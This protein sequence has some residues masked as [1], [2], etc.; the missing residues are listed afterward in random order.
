MKPSR[1]HPLIV[2]ALVLGLVLGAG[3]LWR[4][5]ESISRDQLMAFL[6]VFKGMGPWVF[7]GMM[8]LLPLFWVPVSPFLLL[9]PAFGLQVAVVGSASALSVNLLLAWFVSGKWFRP[10]FVRLVSRFGYSV[11]ELSDR[12]MLGV[13]VLLRITP[14]VP[15]PLQ[16]YLLGLAR[17]PLLKYLAVSLPI[18][19][20]MSASI[21]VLG[22]SIMTG[23]AQL[24]LIAIVLAV[25]I[26]LILRLWRSKLQAKAIVEEGS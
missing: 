24:A 15:F 11:P 14:G 8:A 16:N 26:A 13:A 12:S 25:A 2:L 22:E 20:A 4:F 7:F 3:V 9:A 6:E 5:R 18:V 10:L 21:V 17:M 1:L 19:W 23:N